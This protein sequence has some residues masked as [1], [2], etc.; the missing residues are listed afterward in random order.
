MSQKAQAI[1][2]TLDTHL[3]FSGLSSSEKQLFGPH[4]EVCKFADGTVI[5][6]AD[7]DMTG[8]YVLYSGG[9][10]LKQ[11]QD[12][13]R[14]MLGELTRGATVGELSLVQAAKWP[15]QVVAVGEVV[16]LF[17]PADKAQAVQR[18]NAN[19]TNVLKRQVGLVELGQRLRGMLGGAR[20]TPAQFSEILGRIGIKRLHKDQ[21]LFAQN[22]E[23]PR[24]YYVEQGSLDI[25]INTLNRGEVLLERVGRNRVLGEGAALDDVDSNHRHRH[26]ARAANNVTVLVIG[27]DE[28]RKIFA[29]NPA[30]QEQ[31]RERHWALVEKEEAE[32]D[33]QN[34]AEGIAQ[35]ITLADAV[36][37][38]EYLASAETKDARSFQ[39]V[40]QLDENDVSAACMTMIVKHYGKDF[41]LGQ[42]R[43]LTNLSVENATPAAIITGAETVGFRSRAYGIDYEQLMKVQLPGIV[44]LENYHYAVLYK[45][46]PKEVHLAD[47]AQGIRKLSREEFETS[48]T[49]AQ[50]AGAEVLPD[51]GL[52]IAFDPTEYFRRTEPPARPIYH[53]LAYVLPFKK[54]FAE[55]M[56]A[57]F[58]INVLGLATPLFVQNIIDNVIVHKDSALLNV[59][60]AGMI[61]VTFFTILCTGAQRL[62]L[63]HTTARLDMNIM[64]EFY[65]HV[66]SLPMSFFL[67]RNKGEIMARF[68]ENLKILD[69]ITGSTVTVILNTFMI[70]IY[71]AMMFAY[72]GKLTLIALAFIPFYFFI[73]LFFTPRIKALANE[74]F[75]VDTQTESYLIES[76]NGIETLKATGNEYMARAR[77]ENS[78]VDAVNMEYRSQKLELVSSSLYQLVNLG[79]SVTILWIGATQVMAGA[80][81]VGELMG[82]QMLLGL[83]MGPIMAMLDLWND[84]QEI[85]IAMDRVSDALVV[86]PEQ[87]RFAPDRM[88]IML[89]DCKGRIDF[90][91]VNFS[92]MANGEENAVM[93]NFNL[94]IEPGMR[95]AF[96]GPSGCG[97]STIAKM[98][99]GFNLPNGGEC[100][101]DGKDI[102]SINLPSLRRNIGVVLQDSF[103]FAGTVAE[104]I[105]LGDPEPE[106]Q[107]VKEA[108]RLA[109]ADNFI[110]N[111]PL[112]YNTLVGEKGISVSGGQRQRICIARALYRKPQIMIFDEATSALDN[113]SE[114]RIQEN[115]LSILAGRTSITIAHRL[116]TIIE[117]D[118]ICYIADGNVQE[119]GTHQQLTDPAYLRKNGYAG[120]YYGM[121]KTQFDLPDLDLSE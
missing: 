28:V 64:S 31:L 38:E 47:P 63:A 58:T 119:R 54:F 77:W 27:Q 49:A 80:M 98:V 65:R 89:N 101:I 114:A 48:W 43:E 72:N 66:L 46:T 61:M 67:T 12:G 112:G 103:L 70:V 51:K 57:T 68:G 11:L 74:V 96:V 10:R 25:V 36:T 8:M 23:D 120:A 20:Y 110:I 42:I 14:V 95:V 92:Y 45:I 37:E 35:R 76:L 1:E 21:V 34:R 83:V 100:K 106:M 62:L 88:P 87:D 91:N 78:F 113:E 9:I 85:R 71:L 90:V 18:S 105:A 59:M 108:A 39:L 33:I 84:L 50:I 82:F 104:N 30:L 116:T 40:K 55:S 118:L 26:T 111:Y 19:I 117:S 17:L 94:T 7:S 99:L 69:I 32:L 2:Q 75:Q 6:E 109:G 121:A 16:A 115:M 102:R 79:S 60:L 53:F 24:L 4:F 56:L 22:E 29:I 86:K 107:A 41:T 52:F 93:R 15:Y 97:K 81:T 44:G 3:M 5:A 73:L 13:K